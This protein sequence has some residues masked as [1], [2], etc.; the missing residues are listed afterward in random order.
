MCLRYCNKVVAEEDIICYKV[1]NVVPGGVCFKS[2]VKKSF[3]FIGKKKEI[4]NV[5]LKSKNLSIYKEKLLTNSRIRK[6]DSCAYHTFK[7]LD[8]A[9]SF[10]NC[11]YDTSIKRILKCKIPKNSKYIFEGTF[12]YGGKTPFSENG[13][14]IKNSYA[15][16]KLIPIEE[17]I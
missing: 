4:K 15:S 2:P 16:Q 14:P 3:Y 6:I 1:V 5:S 12:N 10:I 13:E 11:Y 7:T 8:E 9:R 17:I